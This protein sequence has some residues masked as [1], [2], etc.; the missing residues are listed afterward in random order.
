MAHRQQVDTE[1]EGVIV[2]LVTNLI[3]LAVL[4]N[5]SDIHI[6]PE[7]DKIRIR[8][9]IDGVLREVE[10][11]PI[12]LHEPLVARVKVLASMDLAER[13][14]P[15]D[16]RFPITADNKPLDIRVSVFPTIY[17]ENLTM[18]ILNK[19]NILLGLPS[20]GFT[21]A[22]L[23][24]FNQM[25]H[26]PYGIIFVTGPNGSGKTTTLYA[27]LNTIN[28]PDK[29]IVTLE[30]PI[31][32]QLPLIRQTQVDPDAGLTFATG[33]RSLLR[34]DPD[35][36]LVG[37]VRD[38][39]TASIAV[40]SALTGHLVLTTLHTNDS[41][42]AA[43]R[44]VDMGIERVLI[45]SATIGVLA[46]RLVRLLCTTCAEEY[47]A[48]LPLKQQLGLP[49]TDRLTFKKAVGCEVCGYTGYLG[50]TGIFELLNPDKRVRQMIT[51]GASYLDIHS[52]VTKTL[53]MKTLREDGLLKARQGQTSVEEVL[54][55]TAG[56]LEE[57][58]REGRLGPA[59]AAT[60]G[61]IQP[62]S[63]V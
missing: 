45:A 17:G 54:R 6:E 53:G 11:H 43:V 59:Q 56:E 33:L 12:S 3:R 10:T 34:Q 41:V 32:Y 31:E 9:R 42:G 7:G 52:Y 26:Q 57:Y 18:R 5:A 36:I 29:D 4:N 37:E 15:Q 55:V 23:E 25:I 8:F 19:T 39:E 2:K 51:D 1:S 47:E 61:P 20:L 63:P 21:P 46:Q 40:R 38:I 14:K 49:A 60:T 62:A 50:R 48:S 16:G 22:I 24:Q 58:A 27:T 13:R 35:I 30:D 44:L 28:T